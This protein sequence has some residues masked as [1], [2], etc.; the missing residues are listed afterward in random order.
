LFSFKKLFFIVCILFIIHPQDLK[1]SNNIHHFSNKTFNSIRFEG[2]RVFEYEDLAY[3]F[4]PYIDKNIEDINQFRLDIAQS[5]NLHYMARGYSFSM[6]SSVEIKGNE[7]FIQ[8]LEGSINNVV[9]PLD[10]EPI[11]EIK[12]LEEYFDKLKTI[13][14]YNEKEAEK[15]ILLIKRLLGPSVTIIPVFL[16]HDQLDKNDPKTVDLFIADYKKV[17]GS[18]EINNSY[19]SYISSATTNV[20]DSIAQNSGY[21]SM[22]KL[23]TKINNPF[24]SPGNLGTFLTTSG[25]KK[26]NIIF[27]QYQ[28]QI[29]SEGTFLKLSGGYDQFHFS[30]RNK[31]FITIITGLSHPLILTTRDKLNIFT[32]LELYSLQKKYKDNVER[33]TRSNVGKLVLGTNYELLSFLNSK[34]EYEVEVH[35]G[36]AKLKHLNGNKECNN[37]TFSKITF[38]GKAEFPLPQNFKLKLNADAKF[39]NSKNL[40][41]DEG[42]NAGKSIGGRGFLPSEVFGKNG[43]QGSIEISHISVFDH[44]LLTAID[45]YA[46]YDFAKVTKLINARSGNNLSSVG[47]GLDAYLVDNLVI[48]LE[49]NKP[50]VF[51]RYELNS[52]KDEVNTRSKRAKLFAGLKYFFSF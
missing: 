48:N 44:P 43:F 5:I 4:E 21:F 34:H 45:T 52:T 41:I 22:G 40:P 51:N 17:N 11:K 37:S 20:Q 24:N 26:E 38:T 46:Y 49:L 1:A 8:I 42:F 6:V 9:V 47:I 2:L 50:I 27:S 15:Y 36:K 23:V 31:E 18:F 10:F 12:Y 25:D 39:S 7:L 14:P 3:I 30:N 29:N 32:N 13:K 35:L 33:D 28:H 19:N 16:G